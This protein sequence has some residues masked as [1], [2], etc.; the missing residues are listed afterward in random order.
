M[1]HFP[2]IISKQAQLNAGMF[3]SLFKYSDKEKERVFCLTFKGQMLHKFR[4]TVWYFKSIIFGKHCD[5][6]RNGRCKAK[7][8]ALLTVVTSLK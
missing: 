3:L 8:W 7:G 6:V 1:S 4:L 2:E 5:I